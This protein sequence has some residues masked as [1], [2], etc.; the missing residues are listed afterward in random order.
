VILVCMPMRGKARLGF[1]EAVKYRTTKELRMETVLAVSIKE[2]ARRLGVCARTI[3]N[4]LRAKEL[5]SRK[6]G[7]RRVIPVAA[8]ENFLR[9]DH[10]IPA[11]P[12]KVAA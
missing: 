8:L 4:L 9:H 10:R 11:E 1:C 7:R 2:A 5:A 3:H 6:I 12:T